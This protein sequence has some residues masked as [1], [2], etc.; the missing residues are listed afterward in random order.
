MTTQQVT[1]E[2][3]HFLSGTSTLDLS[4]TLDL[5]SRMDWQDGAFLYF[6][7]NTVNT[8]QIIY[9]KT[10]KF[11]LEITNDSED[12]IF[13]QRYGTGNDAIALIRH[14]YETQD[15]GTVT[16]FYEVPINEKTLDQ[17][18]RENSP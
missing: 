9:L 13:Q 16:G 5:F 10:E 1:Y 4:G 11:L 12:M 15:A 6:E 7:I 17:V 8:L 3:Y 14:F 2:D 18:M